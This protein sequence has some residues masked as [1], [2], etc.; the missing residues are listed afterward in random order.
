MASPGLLRL[1]LF[2]L[3]GILSVSSSSI[4]IRLA[5]APS[6]TISF[7]RVLFATL[8]LAPFVLRGPIHELIGLNRKECGALLLSGFALALHFAFWIASLSFTSV[9]SSVLLVNTTPFFVG[10]AGHFFLHKPPGRRFWIGLSISF[11]GC[12]LI[13][14]E[15]WTQA[16][17]SVRGNVLALLGAVAVAVYLLVGAQARQKLS[18][19]AYVWPV[20]GASAVFL[21]AGCA[22]TGTLMG[23]FSGK[24]WIYMFLIGLVPQ[25]IG[26]TTYNWSL[27]WLP[28]ALV[29]LIGLSEPV[30]ASLLAYLVL[31]ESVTRGKLA[32]G[33]IILL[34]I[35]LAAKSRNN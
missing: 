5:S 2:L 16:G 3:V 34:G 17:L 26:H 25:S 18:L 12:L 20:Y 14:R 35:Y 32:G 30:G 23:G 15:D 29:A 9:A 22:M 24:T 10:L 21:L 7:Y 31:H 6:L 28:A 13:F 8:L 4:F 1:I 19:L 11:V 33:A 27:R